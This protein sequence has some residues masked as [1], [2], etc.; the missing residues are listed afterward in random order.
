M[1]GGTT[2]ITTVIF[3]FDGTLATLNIDFAAMRT[4]IIDL[5]AA[6]NVPVDT[7]EN[8]FA[9][10]MIEAGRLLIERTDPGDSLMFVENTYELIR[11]IE[12]EGARNGALFDGIDDMLRELRS[13]KI[14]TG[15]VTRNCLDAVQ[16]ICPDISGLCDIV[17]TRESTAQVKPH[18][19]QLSLALRTLRADPLS[20]AMVGDH[21]MDIAVGKEVGACAI[22]VLTGYG[23][24]EML[25]DAGAD[26]ILDHAT[27]IGEVLELGTMQQRY[28][29]S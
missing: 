27:Q 17:V 1:T 28:G 7:V 15:I 13:S 19:E 11:Q 14:Q 5:I 16:L 6:H 12:I 18:P 22:G 21:P 8:L 9:L 29:C 3:D 26:F 10:E 23:N 4:Q 24:K 20:A 25:R 2:G